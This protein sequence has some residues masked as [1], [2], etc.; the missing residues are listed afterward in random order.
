MIDNIE[1]KKENLH[2]Q[3]CSLKVGPLEVSYFARNI[4]ETETVTSGLCYIKDLL[5]LENCIV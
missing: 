5:F 4:Y 3:E 1:S 2:L